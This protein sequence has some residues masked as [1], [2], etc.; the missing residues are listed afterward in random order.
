M[1]A[2]KRKQPEIKMI[3][4]KKINVHLITKSNE[5]K[6][7]AYLNLK[8]IK[9]KLLMEIEWVVCIRHT[10]AISFKK[11]YHGLVGFPRNIL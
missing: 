2:T 11:K 6:Q 3:R 7:R 9:S 1:I 5:T 8:F 4:K 10:R